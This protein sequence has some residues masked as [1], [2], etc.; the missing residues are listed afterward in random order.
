M[1]FMAGGIEMQGVDE[2]RNAFNAQPF[3]SIC[4]DGGLILYVHVYL[5][6]VFR[7]LPCYVVCFFSFVRWGQA[8]TR[9]YNIECE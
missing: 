9:V 7:S 1:G 4:L 3:P 8:S 5:L 6:Y 2:E